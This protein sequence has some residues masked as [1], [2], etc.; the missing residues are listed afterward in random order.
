MKMGPHV[1]EH[2]DDDI[3]YFRTYIRPHARLVLRTLK[4]LGVKQWVFTSATVGYMNNI[5]CFLDPHDN[6][7][8]AK[9]LSTS[10]FAKRELS[11]KGKDIRLLFEEESPNLSRC[12]MVDDKLKYHKP[13]PEH[14]IFCNVFGHQD[15]EGLKAMN[16][17]NDRELLRVM[18][19]ILR[20]LFVR[21]VR[22]LLAAYHSPEYKAFFQ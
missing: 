14:G 10:D 7:F 9:K 18:S 5:C 13:Q 4:F 12:L 3:M 11:K 17:L 19:I 6:I 20:C 16:V 21:D 15:D 22:P 1:C 8:E 2:I